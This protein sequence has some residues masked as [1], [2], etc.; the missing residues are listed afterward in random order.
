MNATQTLGQ[1]I[2]AHALS[3]V[4]SLHGS[5]RSAAQVTSDILRA[6]GWSTPLGLGANVAQAL[7]ITALHPY[8]VRVVGK[9]ADG[10]PVLSLVG[11]VI[12]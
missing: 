10:R 12:K 7:T 11:E 4:N 5:R 9:G 8:G 3:V 2:E 1:A 6:A